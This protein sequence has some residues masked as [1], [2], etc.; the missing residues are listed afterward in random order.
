MISVTLPC[1]WRGGSSHR[2]LL[3]DETLDGGDLLSGFFVPVD[4]LFA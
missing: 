4:D 3:P 1:P 2:M